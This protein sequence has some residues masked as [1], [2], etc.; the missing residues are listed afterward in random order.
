M[1][2][3]LT[4]ILASSI[5]A[6]S[7]GTAIA[8]VE[9]DYKPN[10]KT[11]IIETTEKDD[12]LRKRLADSLEFYAKLESYANPNEVKVDNQLNLA[13]KLN[14]FKLSFDNFL[15]WAKYEPSQTQS[16][17][18]R[19]LFGRGTNLVNNPIKLSINAYVGGEL[20]HFFK[21]VKELNA[22]RFLAGIG[23]EMN[24]PQINNLFR[25]NLFA[26]FGANDYELKSGYSDKGQYDSF[27]TNAETT[28]KLFSMNLFSKNKE[29]L[30]V[31]ISGYYDKQ[32]LEHLSNSEEYGVR[33]EFPYILNFQN[34]K[35]DAKGNIYADGWLFRVKP[36]FDYKHNESNSDL[37]NR[38]IKTNTY[39]TGLRIEAQYSKWVALYTELGYQWNRI[40]I[41]DPSMNDSNNEKDSLAFRIGVVF[42]K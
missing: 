3:K 42:K 16:L 40:D 37:T 9:T 7:A 13:C 14:K 34:A 11:E 39:E 2:N 8:G 26:G 27:F 25:A 1:E 18:E 22:N 19:G 4:K 41:N 5:L 12:K 6:A 17:T 21:T 33:V 28:Q 35:K 38:E 15:Q 31:K 32:N 10:Q 36:Y 30:Y 29:S 24:T 23:F 20:N